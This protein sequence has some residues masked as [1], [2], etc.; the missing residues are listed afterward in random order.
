MGPD[1]ACNQSLECPGLGQRRLPNQPPLEG[2]WRM[3]QK[4]GQRK[5]SPVPSPTA[6]P[7][8]YQPPSFHSLDFLFSC[9]PILPSELLKD[10]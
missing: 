8:S 9:V 4:E 7:R 5:V 1:L 10:N 6:M 2:T 3:G